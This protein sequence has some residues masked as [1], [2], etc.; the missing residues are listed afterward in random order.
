M[1]GAGGKAAENGGSEGTRAEPGGRR[2][3]E[4][5]GGKPLA[6]AG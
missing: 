5:H 1:G 6:A 2:W 3:E 4:R